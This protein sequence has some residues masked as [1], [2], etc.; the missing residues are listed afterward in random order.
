M[1][2]LQ[3]TDG[4]T[5]LLPHSVGVDALAVLPG[6][7]IRAS[8][9]QAFAAATFTSVTMGTVEHDTA[10]MT[11]TPNVLTAPV[12][13]LYLCTFRITIDVATAALCVS[14]LQRNGTTNLDVHRASG[15]AGTQMPVLLST[16]ASFN[17][18]DSCGAVQYCSTAK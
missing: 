16:V 10:S 13:G 4:R 14:Y 1:D 2:L 18:G 9:N 3:D 17:R 5:A 7:R 12:T 8:A 6:A 11:A 15:V